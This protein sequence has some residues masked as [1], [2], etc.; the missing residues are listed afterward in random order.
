MSKQKLN[1]AY[2]SKDV[3]MLAACE[4]ILTHALEQK[5]ILQSKRSTWTDSFFTDLQTRIQNAYINHLGI[6]SAK[7]LRAATQK[8]STMQ[9]K[10][11]KD[12]AEFKIQ[13]QEDFKK[14]K[15]RLN[16][17]LTNLGFTQYH[18]TAQKG[19]QEALIQLLF[20]LKDNM[21]PELKAEIIEKGT[22]EAVILEIIAYADLLKTY[23]ISQ[24][25]LKGSRK[26]IT[27]AAV[28]EF[29]EIYEQIISIA[30]IAAKFFKD[31]KAVQEQFSFAR[32]VSNLG[33]H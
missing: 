1:R 14:D 26:E 20:Q 23:N 12:L 31:N 27:Q 25:S 17:L 4:T 28:S 5:D 11:L 13:I 2:K 6:D 10:A 19:S 3:D 33:N 15:T 32:T 7:E 21:T 16:E 22:A 8:V 30:K 29:N 18:K 24:E 9:A